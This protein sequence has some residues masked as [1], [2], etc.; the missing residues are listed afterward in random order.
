[1]IDDLEKG[2]GLGIDAGIEMFQEKAKENNEIIEDKRNREL[3][4]YVF[5]AIRYFVKK[6]HTDQARNTDNT[7]ESSNKDNSQ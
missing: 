2:F 4:H 3:Q 1:M 5:A 6:L 7:N